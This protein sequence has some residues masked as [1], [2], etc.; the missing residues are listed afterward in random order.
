MGP[1]TPSGRGRTAPRTPSAARPLTAPGD[2]RRWA[3]GPSADL[4]S[5]AREPMKAIDEAT[6]RH[7]VR[8]PR[9]RWSSRSAPWP[10]R[11]SPPR[12]RRVLGADRAGDGQVTG[13]RDRGRPGLV[14]D[15][16]QRGPD[17]RRLALTAA[18]NSVTAGDFPYVYGGGHAEAGIASIGIKG[19]GYNGRRIGLD[20]SGSV[21]AVLVR[22]RA[23]GSRPPASPTTPGSSP[24]CCAS[25]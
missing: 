1:S 11:R 4:K 2:V 24:S 14:C 5:R 25:T 19:P 22:R 17:V 8:A 16:G 23:S 20:C 18:A 12:P 21:A 3:A 9:W 13:E 10:L 7:P 15:R 6:R